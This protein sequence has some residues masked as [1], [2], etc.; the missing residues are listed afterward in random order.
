MVEYVNVNQKDIKVL[1]KNMK[2]IRVRIKGLNYNY[3]TIIEFIT[4]R[5]D[6]ASNLE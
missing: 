2:K 4:V 3:I 1:I 5:D 6:Q